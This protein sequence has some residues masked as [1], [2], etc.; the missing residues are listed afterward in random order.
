MNLRENILSIHIDDDLYKKVKDNTEQDN[1]TVPK[2][3]GY[4]LDNNGL[5]RYNNIIYI[6]SNDKL[7][8]LI[9]SESH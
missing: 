7:R 8:S 1:M 2:F 9:L 6:P 5:L 3:E 4:S